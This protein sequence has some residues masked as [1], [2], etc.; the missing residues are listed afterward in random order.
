MRFIVMILVMLFVVLQYEFWFAEGGVISAWKLTDHIATAQQSNDQLKQ[1]NDA[2]RADIADLKS[3]NTAIE[4]RARAELGMV[5]RGE[6]F[7][8]VVQHAHSQQN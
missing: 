8:Q 3:G 2:L 1:R 6:T 4:E 5:K 7:Y